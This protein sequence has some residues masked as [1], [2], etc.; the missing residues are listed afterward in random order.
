MTDHQVVDLAVDENF[1]V[2]IDGRGDLAYVNGRDAF[3]Q[4]LRIRIADRYTNIV[5]SV[6]RETVKELL[7]VEAKTVASEM[8]RIQEL[9]RITVSF[10]EEEAN[11]ARVRLV[12]DTG[13]PLEFEVQ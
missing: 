3:E 13:D 8:G 9:H 4:E 12:F 1:E 11:T 10:P 7:K 5:G 6:G 2:F